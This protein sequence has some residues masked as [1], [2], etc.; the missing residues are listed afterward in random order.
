MPHAAPPWSAA[1]CKPWRTLPI[2]EKFVTF[3]PFITLLACRLL[4][5]SKNQET[6][7]RYI[8][9]PFVLNCLFIVMP[10]GRRAWPSETVHTA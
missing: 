3:I 1:Q 7:R 5:C 8:A 6:I 10:H 2:F 4:H 9:R